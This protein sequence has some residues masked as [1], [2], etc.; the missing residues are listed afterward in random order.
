MINVPLTIYKAK[1]PGALTGVFFMIN[2]CI[3]ASKLAL[4][5]LGRMKE[6]LGVRLTNVS[7]VD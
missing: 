1:L 7:L 3:S 4:S 2:Q 5:E 6:V